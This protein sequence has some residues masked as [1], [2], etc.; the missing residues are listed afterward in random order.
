MTSVQIENIVG[1]GTLGI[2]V[3]VAV[4][5]NDLEAYEVTYNPDNYHGLYVRLNESGP[6]ITVYRTGKYIITG[7]DSESELFDTK[8][9]FLSLLNDKGILDRPEDDSFRVNNIVCTADLEYT[10]DLNRLSIALGL[11]QSEYE[12]EQFPGLVHR[13]AEHPCVI[14]LFGSGKCVVTG[15]PTLDA[16]EEAFDYIRNRVDEV[17]KP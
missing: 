5:S 8:D 6:L 2:E 9:Q 12:P 17:L 1:T 11:E 14:L 3:D 16:A 13:P 4:V 7:A 10:I 15:A